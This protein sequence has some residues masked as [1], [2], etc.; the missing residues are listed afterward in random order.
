LNAQSLARIRPIDLLRYRII[1]AMR[2]RAPIAVV[3]IDRH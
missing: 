2:G 3:E 1:R